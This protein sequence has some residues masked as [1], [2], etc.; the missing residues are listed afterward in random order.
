MFSACYV[1][2][3]KIHSSKSMKRTLTRTSTEGY[4]H[5]STLWLIRQNILYFATGATRRHP[6][7]LDSSARSFWIPIMAATNLRCTSWTTTSRK[8]FRKRFQNAICPMYCRWPW[9]ITIHIVTLII[10]IDSRRIICRNIL[11]LSRITI[12]PRLIW[13]RRLLQF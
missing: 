13:H 10:I 7:C 1:I 12:Q 5:L 3:I 8:A 6:T 4:W 2:K 11:R 9:N